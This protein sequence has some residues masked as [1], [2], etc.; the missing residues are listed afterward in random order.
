VSGRRNLWLVFRWPLVIAVLSAVGLTSALIGNGPWDFLSWIALAVP[1]AIGLH[2]L[3]ARRSE[4]DREA[5]T[6]S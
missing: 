1:A 2:K 5:A 3:R 4:R 6:A